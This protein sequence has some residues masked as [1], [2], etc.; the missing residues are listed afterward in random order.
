MSGPKEYSVKHSGVCLVVGYAP[1]VHSD[2]A[3]ARELYPNAPM[4]G[5][6]F[7][8]GLYPEIV[9]VWTTHLEQAGEIKARA[10]HRVYVHARPK[11]VQRKWTMH[12]YGKHEF[13]IDYTWPSLAW[14]SGSSGLAAALWA[15][16]GMGFDTVIMC[17][18]PLEEGGYCKEVAAFK[19][20]RGVRGVSFAPPNAL[21]HWRQALLDYRDKG[22]MQGIYSMSGFTRDK[23]G[24]PDGVAQDA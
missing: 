6:K 20:L 1:D 11:K 9:H 17:G 2:V 22:K 3:R 5:A 14:V 7:A 12:I 18:I 4:L 8:A 15:R 13:D 19:P 16:W 23:L 24:E 10:G 21:K